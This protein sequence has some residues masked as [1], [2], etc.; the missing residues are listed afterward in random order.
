[1]KPNMD[2]YVKTGLLLAA[3]VAV[4]I[5]SAFW[6][7]TFSPIASPWGLRPFPPDR[8]RGDL[9]LFY[10]AKTVISSVNMTLLTILL[11]TYI[12]IYKETQSEFTLG[13]ILFS[14][15]LLLYALVSNPIVHAIFGFKAFGLGPFVML[16]D[17][18]SAIALSVLLY[19]TIKY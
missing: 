5:L 12:S 13:L 8:I 3:V 6:A 11:I 7:T 16:P 17:L 19:L 2:R 15:I 1:M 14:I 9:E 10:T 4:A 18:F